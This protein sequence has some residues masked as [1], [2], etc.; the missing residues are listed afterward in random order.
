MPV[1]RQQFDA[2]S[3]L[4]ISRPEAR[5][6]WGPDFF[7]E[8]VSHFAELAEDRSV[9]CVV[10]TGDDAGKAFSA[11]ANLKDPNS[12]ASRTPGNF[13]R[14]LPKRPL[15]AIPNVINDFPKPIVAAVNGF[16]IGV[17]CIVSCSCDIVVASERAEWRL[18]QASL[19]IMPQHAAT[20]RIAR[21]VGRANAMKLLLG[22]PIDA[23]EGYRLGLAQWLVPHSELMERTMEIAHRIAKMPPLAVRLIKESMNKGMDIANLADTALLDSYRAMVLDLSQDSKESHAAWREKRPPK[24]EGE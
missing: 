2:V 5:N 18:T 6:C 17:G 15:Q 4:T 22:F 12:H 24:F 13:V 23:Q 10:I 14:G 16:A 11:G 20:V 19:G 1:L 7:A 3:V 9:N 21:W 8:F